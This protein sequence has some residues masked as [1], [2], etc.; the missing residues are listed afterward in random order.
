MGG[1]ETAAAAERLHRQGAT[2]DGVRGD[3]A[4]ASVEE[5]RRAV[6]LQVV[7]PLACGPSR[8]KTE[9][10]EFF[11]AGIPMPKGSKTILP[12]GGKIGGRPILADARRGP[13]RK[14]YAAWSQACSAHAVAW[15]NLHVRSALRD[16]AIAVDLTFYL[17]RPVAAAKRSH[18]AKRPDLDKLCRSVLDAI[19]P[20]RLFWDDSRVC[21]LV[22]RK[23][24]ASDRGPG[25]L[26]RIWEV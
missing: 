7:Q 16:V 3:R 26:V 24:Y 2:R 20:A 5:R 12:M 17:P 11:V 14:A 21:E 15:S 10:I 22:A 4:C 19:A 1:L 25:V 18:P 23:H 9:L 6:S 13:A 8:S